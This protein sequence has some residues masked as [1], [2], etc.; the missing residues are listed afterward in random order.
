VAED[1]VAVPQPS[2]LAL[3]RYRSGNIIW[4][5]NQLWGLLIPGR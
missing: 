1:R 2:E 4:V 5:V 3:E